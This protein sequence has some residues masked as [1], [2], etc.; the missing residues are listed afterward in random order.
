[1]KQEFIE[2]PNIKFQRKSS[3]NTPVFLNYN[4]V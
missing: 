1:M 3:P 2:L 4:K